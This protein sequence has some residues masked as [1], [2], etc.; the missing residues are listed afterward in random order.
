MKATCE[1]SAEGRD[2][3]PVS[4]GRRSTGGFALLV[5]ESTARP[6]VDVLAG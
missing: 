1:F 4:F 2:I 3:S 5:V 6:L